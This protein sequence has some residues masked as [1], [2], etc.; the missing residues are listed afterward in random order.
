MTNASL[1]R[2]KCCER[3]PPGAWG[4]LFPLWSGVSQAGSGSGGGA[5]LSH[6]LWDEQ[7]GKRLGRR[8]QREQGC[9]R[10]MRLQRALGGTGVTGK[11]PG[12][13]Q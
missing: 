1:S 4:E 11:G 13:C 2:T 3:E 9:R 7:S 6:G 8:G 12:I 5:H 10:V